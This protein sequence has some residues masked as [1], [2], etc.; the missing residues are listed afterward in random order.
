MKK[1]RL[2]TIIPERRSPSGTDTDAERSNTTLKPVVFPS[3][4]FR[5]F[6]LSQVFQMSYGQYDSVIIQSDEHLGGPIKFGD[7]C[8]STLGTVLQ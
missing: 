5:I 1:A 3:K 6:S 7:M 2:E 4:A 8:L